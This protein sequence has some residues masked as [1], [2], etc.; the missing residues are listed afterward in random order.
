MELPY[1]IG[2]AHERS[3]D[4]V[5]TTDELIFHKSLAALSGGDHARST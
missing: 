5:T 3:M 1:N 2:S 4:H